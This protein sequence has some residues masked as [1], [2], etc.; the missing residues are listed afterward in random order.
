MFA[1]FI[2]RLPS[3]AFREDRLNASLPQQNIGFDLDKAKGPLFAIILALA[4]IA[5]A[6]AQETG[7]RESAKLRA[8]RALRSQW[9]SLCCSTAGKL[10]WPRAAP[11]A[12][13]LSWQRAIRGRRHER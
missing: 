5:L 6:G 13:V 1:S 3:L 7:H 12:R 11:G 8:Q 4:A 10:G 2:N 9:R